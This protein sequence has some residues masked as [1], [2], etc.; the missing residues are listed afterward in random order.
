LSRK[1]FINDGNDTID[2]YPLPYEGKLTKL[3]CISKEVFKKLK[4]AL[5]EF[6]LKPKPASPK[7]KTSFRQKPPKK[8]PLAGSKNDDLQPGRNRYGSF[9][10]SNILN[11]RH[12]SFWRLRNLEAWFKEQES[13]EDLRYLEAY[14]IKI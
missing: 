4:A 8:E 10:P 5:A 2:R 1:S 6:G 11:T 12:S 3:L 7:P 13:Y 14:Q 9:E